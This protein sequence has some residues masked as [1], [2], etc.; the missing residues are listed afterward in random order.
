MAFPANP[1]RVDVFVGRPDGDD[2][3][4][5]A[6]PVDLDVPAVDLE[7]AGQVFDMDAAVRVR[8]VERPADV[9]RFDIAMLGPGSSTAPESVEA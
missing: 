1:D 8:H 9:F 2:R 3:R 5:Q 4:L 7:V 6:Q